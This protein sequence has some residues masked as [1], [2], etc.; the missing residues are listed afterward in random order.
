[1]KLAVLG[2]SPADEAA[3]RIIVNAILAKKTDASALPP[4]RSRGWPS[5]LDDVNRV[6]KY[7]H[8]R[9]PQVG[10][11]ALVVDSN[12]TAAHEPA[13]DQPGQENPQCRLCKIRMRI[14]EARAELRLVPNR[15]ELR[16][17]VGL[18]VPQIEAWYLCGRNPRVSEAA[19]IQ[20][21]KSPPV[22]YE[23]SWLKRELYGTERPTLEI[24]TMHAV[25]EASR[26]A[27]NVTPLETFFP[28]GF[29]PLANEIRRWR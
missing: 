16:V 26:P 24:E 3:L 20:G 14:V 10:G 18:A 22:P 13:H 19:W 1:M 8:Y 23:K 12:G 5:I 4:I 6:M 11:L 2:E 7:L 29:Q 25:R 27:Q 17:A 21:Q 28:G 15:P 9:E